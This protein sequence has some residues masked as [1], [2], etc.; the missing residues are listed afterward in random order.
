M[1]RF[2][3]CTKVGMEHQRANV[4]P[5]ETDEGSWQDVSGPGIQGLHPEH[6]LGSSVQV[7][8]LRSAVPFIPNI[9]PKG[10]PHQFHNSKQVTLFL[11]SLTWPED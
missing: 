9:S 10:L 1:T 4:G 7:L 2:A 6:F 5:Q 11:A 3:R 8:G